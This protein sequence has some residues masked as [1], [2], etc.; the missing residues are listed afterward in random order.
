MPNYRLLLEYDGS[1]FFGWQIQPG[2]RTVQ[3]ELEDAVQTLTKERVRIHCAGRTDRGVHALG[4]VANFKL[5]DYW[6]P[7]KIQHALNGI[8]DKD[9]AVLNVELVPDEFHARFD[10]RARQYIYFFSMRPV[11]VG[12]HYTFYCKF[13][14]DLQAMRAA[15]EHLY[16]EHHFE[17][18]SQKTPE[19]K[20]YL[21]HIE[22]IE[23]ERQGDRIGFRIRANRFLHNMVR[24][25]MG[26]LIQVGRG[27][28][29][30]DDFG[31]ILAARSR[32][33]IGFKAPAHGLFL[34]KV[35]Y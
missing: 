9:I 7:E 8:T 12:R 22:L 35:F 6:Q 3:G 33:H 10:A 11:A 27:K 2:L 31:N 14:L 23:W 29:T 5:Q 17:A 1:H 34:E 25:I 26:T 32:D 21:S 28:L 16:G 24:I 15:A 18:F 13:D 30:P 19:E 20:H 4:Q